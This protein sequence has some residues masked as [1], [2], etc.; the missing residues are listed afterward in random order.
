MDRRL[1]RH[2]AFHAG[3]RDMAKV[4]PGMM[5]WG[6][7]TGVA[8]TTSGL[9][10]SVVL[11]LSLAVF[12]ASAQLS[13]VP[14]MV[15]GAPLWVVCL[16][17]LCVN[18]R[19]VIF[20]AQLRPHMMTLPLRWRL[21]AGYLSA[22]V[23]YVLTVHRHGGDEPAS[24]R[25]PEP[26]A[27]FMGLAVVNWLGWNVASL[28]GIAFAS[29]IPTQWGLAFAGSLALLA[30]LVTLIKDARVAGATTLA[31]VA[32]V[33]GQGLPFRLNIVVAVLV[34]VGAGLWMERQAARRL[35]P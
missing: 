21:V 35:M 25:N 9:P 6:L 18:L 14:L 17:A 33:W 10:L 11:A 13:A 26:L 8:M 31:A 7:V 29:Q 24:A 22:D 3:M 23:T 5:A 34:A 20:S 15:A 28:V 27:Y 1:W 19:F 32:A 2:A 16:T 12:A 30:L 4:M